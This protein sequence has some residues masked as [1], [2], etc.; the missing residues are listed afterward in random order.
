MLK[1][2]TLVSMLAV[3]SALAG[4]ATT[5]GPVAPVAPVAAVA[6]TPPEAPKPQ[7]RSYI[8]SDN[9]MGDVDAALERARAS[10]KRVL[11]VMGANWCSDSRTL[12][13][14]LETERFAA[15]I[16]RKYELVF[17]NIGMPRTGDGHNLA[18]ARRFGLPELPGLPNVLVLTADGT[19]VNP[20]TAT[21]WRNAESRSGDAI[22]EE[23]AM[24]ADRGV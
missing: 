22:Y 13:G 9:A 19:L 12:A 10:G 17:V 16:D 15:L 23:L 7:A 20:T 11:L 21:S 2:R 4:C 6:P 24:L 14:W 8:V 3:A 1:M 5:S 18:I